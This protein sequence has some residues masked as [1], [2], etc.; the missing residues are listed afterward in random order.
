MANEAA[1]I[2]A[3]LPDNLKP[4]A[5]SILFLGTAAAGWVAV[6]WAKKKESEKPEEHFD[7][8]DILE[9]SHI[10]NFLENVQTLA[11]NARLQTEA[12]K[13]ISAASTIIG[14]TLEEDYDE[15]RVEREVSR[16]LAEDRLRRDM[17][18]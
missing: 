10:K 9:S 15:R 6:L 13:N 4:I 5:A 2:V 7:A 1:E 17:R 12:L 18:S 11:D 14:K 16:R 8:E 3:M